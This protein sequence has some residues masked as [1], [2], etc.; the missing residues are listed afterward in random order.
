MTVSLARLTTTLVSSPVAGDLAPL[1]QRN[2]KSLSPEHIVDL[3]DRGFVESELPNGHE[4]LIALRMQLSPGRLVIANYSLDVIDLTEGEIIGFHDFYVIVDDMAG[5]GI[6]HEANEIGTFSPETQARL[7]QASLV[8]EDLL[9]NRLPGSL[10]ALWVRSDYRAKTDFGQ[11]T[12]FCEIMRSTAFRIAAALG[13]NNWY[14]DL[15]IF[16]SPDLNKIAN[17]TRYYAERFGAVA[18]D[19]PEQLHIPLV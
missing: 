5:A 16:G 11:D 19:L 14:L 2:S 13:A 18:A 6:K 3:V 4:A 1:W 15:D 9:A 8:D 17:L 12:R 10:D 7:A